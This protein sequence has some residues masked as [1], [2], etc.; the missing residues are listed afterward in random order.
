MRMQL[1][2]VLLNK[3]KE[4]KCVEREKPQLEREKLRGLPLEMNRIEQESESWI[5]MKGSSMSLALC[6]ES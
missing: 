6:L 3:N 1:K 5:D 4:N 2:M